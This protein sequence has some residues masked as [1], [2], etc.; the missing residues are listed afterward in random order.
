MRLWPLSENLPWLL[1]IVFPLKNLLFK[2]D[3]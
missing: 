3:F 1:A 2:I